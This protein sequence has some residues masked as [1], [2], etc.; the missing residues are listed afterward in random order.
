MDLIIGDIIWDM[1]I[2]KELNIKSITL[3]NIIKELN[4]N[5]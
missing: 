3:M 2:V 1:D 4:S 5:L